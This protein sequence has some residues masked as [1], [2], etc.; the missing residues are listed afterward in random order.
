M[1]RKT[2]DRFA[3]G[4]KKAGAAGN[5]ARLM[6]TD[7]V[8]CRVN[9]L[10]QALTASVLQLAL[11]CIDRFVEASGAVATDVTLIPR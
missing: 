4:F 5:A 3:A 1:M 8:F 11:E 6:K 7:A 9:E 10:R 2:S